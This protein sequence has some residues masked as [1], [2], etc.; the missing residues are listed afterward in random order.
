MSSYE[1]RGNMAHLRAIKAGE[2]AAEL[3][4]RFARALAGTASTA[5]TLTMA[6]AAAELSLR[7]RA[8]AHEYVSDAYRRSAVAHRAAAALAEYTGQHARAEHH[9]AAAQADDEAASAR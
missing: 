7:R 5:E 9:R 6:R 8:A 4:R 3:G 1:E 2:R